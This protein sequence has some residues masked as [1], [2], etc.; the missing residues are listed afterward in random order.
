MKALCEKVSVLHQGRLIDFQTVDAAV[1]FY[2]ESVAERRSDP[3]V[4]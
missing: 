4:P 1:A 3:I 2:E